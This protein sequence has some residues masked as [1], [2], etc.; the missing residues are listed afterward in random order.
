MKT[1]FVG[2]LALVAVNV[3]AAEP[4]QVQRGAKNMMSPTYRAA[5]APVVHEFTSKDAKRLAAE[6]S[7]DHLKLAAFYAA[8]AGGLDA[9]GAAYE[10]AAA[11]YRDRPLAKN[12]ASPTAPGRYEFLAKRFHQQAASNR[13]LALAHREMASAAAGL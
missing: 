9:Q 10:S 13:V 12:V 8:E 3:W 6:S 1:V 4:A 5:V 2:L 7:V 11:S